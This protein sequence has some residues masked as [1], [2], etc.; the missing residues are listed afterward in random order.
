MSIVYKKRF[1]LVFLVKHPKGPQMSVETAAKYLQKS[2]SWANSVLNQYNTHKNVDF[3]VE[4]GRKKV[5]TEKQD[6]QI[7]KMALA[8]EPLSTQQIADK[9]VKKGVTVSRFTVGNRLRTHGLGFKNCLKKPLL[10]E[11]HIERRLEWAQRHLDHDWTRVIFSDESSFQL[12]CGTTHAWQVRGEP[13]LLRTVKHPPK[14]N[15]WGCF[16]AKG[17]GKLIF[18]SGTLESNQMVKI[19]S[20]GLLPSAQ[21]FFGT[22]DRN[23]QLLEDNDPKHTSKLSKTWKTQNGVQVIQWP[24][25]SPDC[26]PIENV[27]SLIKARIRHKKIK[28]LKGLIR[29]I[30]FEWSSLT[31]EYARKLSESC[32]HRCEAVLANRGD[33]I[34]Y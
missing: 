10:S 23:W 34:P 33:W 24:A 28:T 31:I 16:S 22:K 14:V 1:E 13:R 32:V 30:K 6:V 2:R 4:K 18:I 26:N 11:I 17:F 27:W 19:Y 3:S 20:R 9:M 21:K 29:A 8:P 12:M 25:Q 5:T 15:V 7:V